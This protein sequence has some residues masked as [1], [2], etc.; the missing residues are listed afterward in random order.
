ME[1]GKDL[2]DLS[3]NAVEESCRRYLVDKDLNGFFERTNQEDIPLVGLSTPDWEEKFQIESD[4]Y[5]GYI[6]SENLCMVSGRVTL[7]DMKKMDADEIVADI[8]V[9][10]SMVEKDIRYVSVH[11]TNP[12]RKTLT[13]NPDMMLDSEYRRLLDYMYDFVIEYRIN[14][15]ALTYSKNKYRELFHKEANFVNMDQWFWDMCSNFVVKQDVEKMDMFRGNDI[16]K[17]LKNKDYMFETDIR[18]KRDRDEIVWLKLN[19]AL[20][21]N[22]NETSIEKTFIL[23]KDYSDEMAEKM[24]N[25][26][27]ARMD[28]LTNIWNRRY[29]EE[30]IAK[31][32]AS[33][34]SGVFAI[35]DI[36]HF[37]SV[38]DV[39][40]HLTGDELL[41]EICHIVSERITE[42]DVFGRLGGDEFVLYLANDDGYGLQRFTDIF[43]SMRFQYSE[44]NIVMDIHCSAGALLVKDKNSTFDTLYDMADNILYEAKR[45]GRGMFKTT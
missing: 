11:M 41:K 21:P 27:Y 22:E 40:G 14:D 37:K 31:K 9:L 2:Y 26:M 3:V 19:F 38:N 33:K 5:Q 7:K 6:Q 36:D 17:R 23:M 42:D 35:F 18:I 25:I 13:Y 30:L 20:V 12:K 45:A 44:D 39:Y 24:T 16:R 8:T 4:H 1:N 34:G 43:E 15:N 32:V 29:A 28:P 10:C